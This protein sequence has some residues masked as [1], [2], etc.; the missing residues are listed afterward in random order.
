MNPLLEENRIQELESYNISK[1][2]PKKQLQ[3]VIKLAAKI[4]KVPVSLIDIIDKTN[5]RTIVAHGDWEEKVIPR[6]QSI[7]DIVVKKGDLLIANDIR[8][9]PML[10]DRLTEADKEKIRFY[11]GAPLK[12]S[13]GYTLGALCVIDSRPRKLSEFQKERVNGF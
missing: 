4:C 5:Q 7:C 11:A 12:S 10:S 6:G 3:S 8:K 2:Y 13:A 9:H 1:D